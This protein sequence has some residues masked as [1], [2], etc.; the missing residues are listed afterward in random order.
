MM[1]PVLVGPNRSGWRRQPAFR[2]SDQMQHRS[3]HFPQPAAGQAYESAGWPPAVLNRVSVGS[4][5]GTRKRAVASTYSISAWLTPCLPHLGQLPASHSTPTI[6][7]VP[8][9]RRLCV[10]INPASRAP[11]F[12]VQ[13]RHADRGFRLSRSS[14]PRPVDR[15]GRGRRDQLRAPG[16]PWR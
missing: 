8:K 10:Q 11:W 16:R 13:A 7:M 9:I 6:F 5:S 15:A 2:T 14:S 4:G 3:A 1:S 12:N